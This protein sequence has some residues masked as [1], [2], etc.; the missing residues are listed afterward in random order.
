M[1]KEERMVRE[2]AFFGRQRGNW[3]I[4]LPDNYNMKSEKWIESERPF[5][6][7]HHINWTNQTLDYYDMTREERMVRERVFLVRQC[8]NWTIQSLDNYDMNSEKWI[9]MNEPSLLSHHVNWTNQSLYY[10][11]KRG[12]VECESAFL[13]RHCGNWRNISPDDCVMKRKVN[14]P[15]L[16][17]FMK[18]PYLD[19]QDDIEDKK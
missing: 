13:S 3:T 5:T 6:D 18:N 14:E 11:T 16:L 1:T 4:Q 7:I 17:Q 19:G 2:R 12:R 15:L 10:Y 8:G 9:E